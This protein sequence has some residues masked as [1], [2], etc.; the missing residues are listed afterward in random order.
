MIKFIN[1]QV[2]AD[3]DA[4]FNARDLAA[5]FTCDVTTSCVLSTEAYAFLSAK[6]EILKLMEKITR[7]IMDNVLRGKPMKLIPLQLEN[8]FIRIMT[9]AISRRVDTNTKRDDFL[10][11]IVTVKQR[12]NQNEVE[13]AAHGW[14]LYFDSYETSSVAV[15]QA[16]YE[17]ANDKRVQ[18]KLREEI[19]E[20]LDGDG[21]L[22][23][24]KISELKYLDQVFYEVLRLHPPFMFTTKVCSED[25]ELDGMKDHKFLM[26]KDSTV[27]ISIYSIHRDPGECA[28]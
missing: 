9:D 18:D 4:A 22:S 5:R 7:G 27:L 12:K 15:M 24:E 11:H 10:S 19:F 17:I 28:F 20:N 2:L 8:N 23:F 6:S 26:E 3:N 16:L 21:N 14:T 13:A 1:K 25:V